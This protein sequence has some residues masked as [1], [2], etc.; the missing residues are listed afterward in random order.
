MNASEVADRLFIDGKVVTMDGAGSIAQAIAVKGGRILAIGTTAQ[1]RALVGGGTD[2]VDLHG[3]TVI[4]GLI[5]THCH[6]V[7]SVR[8]YTLYLDGHVPPNHSIHDL[9]ARIAE[10]VSTAQP[11][12]WIIVHGSHFGARKLAEQRYPNLQELDAVAPAHP[13]LILDGRHT[14]RVNTTALRT[15]GVD[16]RDSPK[17][18][19]GV[20]ET[21]PATGAL[22]GVLKSTG[23]LFP[24][25]THTFDEAKAYVRDIV[26]ALWVTKGFT[27]AFTFADRI[28]FRACQELAREGRLP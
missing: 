24:D 10:T 15:L 11:D 16:S 6:F 3:R 5:D 7:S 1:V 22:T 2:I 14:F 13:V 28:E 18:G 26:P 21:D 8:S 19:V 23:H 9:L 4:P 27:S 20:A 17:M 25:R 12:R